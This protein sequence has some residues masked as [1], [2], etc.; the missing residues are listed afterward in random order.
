MNQQEA[1]K[2][3]QGRKVVM[4]LLFPTIVL[5]IYGVLYIFYPQK[6]AGAFDISGGILRN[7]I[8][9]ML[10]V[11][12]VMFVFNLFLKPGHIVKYLGKGR[13]VKGALL[14]IAAGII[15]TGPIYA[16]YPLLRDLRQ[17]GANPSYLAIFLGNRAIKLPLLPIMVSYFGVYYVILLTVLVI[18][19]TL[20][21]GALIARFDSS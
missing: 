14:S 19:A 18:T 12:A 3:K 1:K 7:L 20:I 5:L 8:W 13:N 17:K 16:W 15:S 2:Q 9:P 21:I 4:L 11:F 6:I 10:C